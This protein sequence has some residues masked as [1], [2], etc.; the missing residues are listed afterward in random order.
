M[1]DDDQESHPYGFTVCSASWIAGSTGDDA[2][3]ACADKPPS[4]SRHVLRPSHSAEA[5]SE[6]SEGSRDAGGPTDPRAPMCRHIG[7][8]RRSRPRPPS[9]DCRNRK[10]AFSP[11][12]RARC[13][14]FAPH[15]P[16]WSEFS[17]HRCEP[18]R[19]LAAWRGVTASPP[20][21]L[22]TPTCRAGNHAAWTCLAVGV[23]VAPVRGHALR[24]RFSTPLEAPSDGPAC[25]HYQSV[26]G[27]PG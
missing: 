19:H 4:F 23:R 26:G 6:K 13:L 16:R 5:P 1:H 17:N 24:S 21:R 8:E 14:R 9:G 3:W 12:S 20:K 25:A 2:W 27:V 10:S 22:V 7:A 18:R 15:V 11:A